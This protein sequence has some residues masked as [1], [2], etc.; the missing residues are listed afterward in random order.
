MK[1]P[2]I[3]TA[4]FA[5]AAGVA[6]ADDTKTKGETF[7]TDVKASKEPLIAGSK[8]SIWIPGSTPSVQCIFAINMRGAGG[9]LFEQD[10]EWRALAKRTHSA[11]LFCEFE[12]HGVQDNGYGVSMLKACEQFATAVNRPELKHAPFVLWGHSMGGRVVQDFVRFHPSRVLAFHIAL[13]ANPSDA[14]FMQEEAIS[15]KV[16]GLYLM[17]AVDGKPKDIR[18]HFHRSRASKSP[19]AWIWLPGQ[20]HWPK[21]MHFKKNETTAKDWRAWAANDV[22]IPWTETMIRLRLPTKEN[23][24]PTP[25]KLRNIQIDK[26]WLGSIDSG[27]LAPYAAFKGDKSTASWYPNQKVANAW[28]KFA[29]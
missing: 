14:E 20:S 5:L 1:K 21:G 7:Q 23:A 9:H 25:V 4:V 15:M 3:L 27:I 24:E 11:I 13:R 2:L 8:Y 6:F 18:N 10:Q 26:G 16:P 19:R 28:V 29:F 17:G 12:A 22:V